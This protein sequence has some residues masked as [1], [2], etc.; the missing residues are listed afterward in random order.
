MVLADEYVTLAHA[1]HAETRVLASRFIA[2]AVPA[3]SKEEVDTYLR[4]IRT[5]MHGATHHCFA[6]RLG[7]ERMESRASD[8]GE[9]VGTAGRPILA[10]IDRRGL[11]NVVVVVTRYFG[12]TKLGTGGLVRAY[13]EAALLALKAGGRRSEV[14]TLP[15]RV[16]VE[17]SNVSPVLHVLSRCGARVVDTQYHERVHFRVE[18]RRSR[19]TALREELI[20]ATSGRAQFDD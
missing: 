7:A 19:L 13:G 8:A 20:Q 5:S 12:G 11:T 18:V 10:A 3:E 1:G 17:Y 15:L 9:P 4:H 14:I 2:N 6:Y 16:S